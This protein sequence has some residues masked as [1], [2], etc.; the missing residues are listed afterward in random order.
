[1]NKLQPAPVD[2]SD[3]AT[4]LDVLRGFALL[5]V[6]MDNMFGFTGYSFFTQAQREG[7]STFMSDG[8]LGISELAFVHG[9]F[10]SLFSLLF[11]IGFSIILMRNEQKGINPLKI[12]YRRLFIL[13][14]IGAGH[15]FLLWEGDILVLYALLGFLLPLF[16]K[17]SDKT[18]L[19]LASVLVLSPILIDL[20][21]VLLHV[22]TGA[23]LDNLAQTVDKST[24][25]PIDD[26]FSQYLYKEGSGWQEWRNWQASGY[27]Y[28]Y[29][30]LIE[31]NRF[32]KVFGMFLIGFLVGR[33][34]M[35]A[36]LEDYTTL[37]KKLRKWGFIIGIPGSI[38]LAGFE[39]FGKPVPNPIGLAHTTLYAIS[40]V[41]LSLAYISWLCLHWVNTKGNTRFKW[42][43]PLGRMALSNYIMQTLLGVFIFYGV[44][45][46]IGG[47]IGPTLFFPIAF[48]IYIFQILFSTWWL[49][50]F[51]YGPL[52]WIWRMLTYGKRLKIVKDKRIYH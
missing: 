33:K 48:G 31:S 25:L 27:L 5:G 10:Y 4:I 50:H 14:L 39:I 18:L 9:K 41:P 43:A 20:V 38:A 37:F 49:K 28:R 13:L 15:L 17:C 2:L 22:K 24:G 36:H 30:Y 16:R 1:M 42:L 34:M 21:K 11:G 52:E 51:N 6:L 26:T 44:G 7:L 40:V 46:G 19:I 29:A 8:I 45:L 35:Y 3:R 12:F 47:S 23:F 32:P